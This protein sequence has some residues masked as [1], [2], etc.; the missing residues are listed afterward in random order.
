MIPVTG[1]VPELDAVDFFSTQSEPV[2]PLLKHLNTI[3]FKAVYK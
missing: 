2:S 1:T 3:K